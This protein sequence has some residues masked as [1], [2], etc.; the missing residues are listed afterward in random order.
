[1]LCSRVDSTVQV[2]AGS[3][4]LQGCRH[5][6][7]RSISTSPAPACRLGRNTSRARAQLNPHASTGRQATARCAGGSPRGPCARAWDFLPARPP[8]SA[9][10]GSARARRPAAGRPCGSTAHGTP[11]TRARQTRSRPCP[12]RTAARA[13]VAAWP[14]SAGPVHSDHRSLAATAGRQERRSRHDRMCARSRADGGRSQARTGL[15]QAAEPRPTR[16]P[17]NHS[18]LGCQGVGG[19]LRRT[20]GAQRGAQARRAA[21]PEVRLRKGDGEEGAVRGQHPAERAVRPID[22]ALPDAKRKHT[23]KGPT[24]FSPRCQCRRPARRSASR[25]TRWSRP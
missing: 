23:A 3:I 18:A 12:T 9:R 24:P 10:P 21:A 14:R 11:A 16:I 2:Y 1:M 5:A 6:L 8:R 13:A 4:R 15:Q 25:Q 17:H 20:G 7:Q 19:W 22:A